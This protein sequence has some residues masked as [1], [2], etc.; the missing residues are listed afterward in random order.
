MK[1]RPYELL[2]RFAETG[3]VA[4]A[5]V[6]SIT[7]VDGKDYQSDP[8]PLSGTTDPAFVEFAKLFSA[9]VIDELNE[10]KATIRLRDATIAEHESSIRDLTAR[11]ESLE[12]IILLP[13]SIT[14]RQGRLALH[15]R[16]LIEKVEDLVK[17]AGAVAQ[18]EYE[19]DVWLR[20][21]PTLIAMASA[22]GIEADQLDQLFDEAKL[23]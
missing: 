23:L 8:E 18:I 1:T 3:K 13:V 22:V 12:T 6:S 5:S 21:N 20:S 17:S 7:T 19:A 11:L 10:A 14:R 16:G 4:G 9:S 15:A 2:V